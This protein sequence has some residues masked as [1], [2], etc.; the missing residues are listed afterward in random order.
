[1]H[2]NIK[3][4]KSII[5]VVY[6]TIFVYKNYYYTLLKIQYEEIML[7]NFFK[8]NKW[9]FLTLLILLTG[10]LLIFAPSWLKGA[11]FVGGGDVK[12]QW[13]PFYVL[14]RRAI[15]NAIKN[16]VMPFYSWALFL[17]NNIWASKSSYGLFDIYNL[18][19]IVID[20][21][22]FFIYNVLSILK[23]IV[24]G[25]SCYAFIKYIFKNNKVAAIAGILYGLSSYSIYFMSQPGFQSFYSLVPLY[26]L[27][28]EIHL[29]KKGKYLFIITVFVMLL[30]N[31]YLFYAISVF[32][33]IYFIYRYYLINKK[34][35]GLIVSAIQL[36]GYY[37]VGVLLS[38]FVV[39][40]AFMYVMQNPRIGRTMPLTFDDLYLYFH[41][42]F[43]PF[44]PNQLYIYKNNVFDHGAHY[45]KEV[46]MY[47]GTICS[48]L[49][50]QFLVTK[51]KLFRKATTIVYLLLGIILF[52]PRASSIINGFSEPCYRWLFFLVLMNIYVTSYFLCNKG[53]INYKFLKYTCLIEIVVIIT[54]FLLGIYNRGFVFKDYI[55]HFT[56]AVFIVIAIII[57]TIL[58]NKNNK[59]L[60]LFI[61]LEMFVVSL[62]NSNNKDR[63]TKDDFNYV[64][65]VL[66]DSDDPNSLKVYLNNLDSNNTNEYFRTYISFENLYWG[67]SRDLS[68]IYNVNDLMSYDS[69]YAP[70]FSAMKK[71]DYDG[72]VY[73][74]EWDYDITNPD[75]INFLNTKYS[76][77]LYENEIPFNNYKIVD[78]TYRGSLIVAENKDYRPLA[79]TYTNFIYYD[80]YLNGDHSASMLNDYVISDV[81]VAPYLG[82]TVSS[83]E[84]VTYYNNN[85]Q[86][87]INAEENGFAVMSLPYDRGWN[88]TINGDK[89]EY[90]ECNGGMIGFKVQ[91]GMNDIEMK[92]IPE[93]FKLGC[94]LTLT[95]SLLLIG[96]VIID[97]VRKKKGENTL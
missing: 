5:Y 51:D 85:L 63:V 93:G 89:V 92:F 65:N 81:D 7:T 11:Y 2:F 45:L 35:K 27:G 50:P 4:N 22:Y 68:I 36:I 77:T 83:I 80:R 75:I 32:S 74:I 82:N 30:M 71:I 59:Y 64:T 84:N 21:N 31:F 58:L 61:C 10:S 19:S 72:V 41:L 37:F 14:C 25:L 57:F 1:M 94:I 39:A 91:K 47:A 29:N 97:I 53:S 6:L 73:H 69:M 96:I 9:L 33:P 76:I 34:S 26:F 15:V 52:V 3:Y 38:G 23:I 90:I 40:P 43:S 12:T 62:A 70:S 8:K 86:G 78:S 44:I 46:C 54:S 16:Q 48:L 67:F 79:T 42:F 18:L 88:I 17:G 28:V 95:G 55:P 60:T 49:V 56:I 66:A 13:F 24:S 87:T 20:N